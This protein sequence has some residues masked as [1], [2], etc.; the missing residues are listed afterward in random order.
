MNEPTQEQIKRFW[1]HCGFEVIL[2]SY[3]EAP[4]DRWQIPSG[5]MINGRTWCFQNQVSINLN[6]LFRYAVPLLKETCEEWWDV[7]VE[8]AKGITGNYKKDTLALFWAIYKV[9]EG[10][11]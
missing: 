11:S 1:E 2:D 4:T 3:T 10:E 8:W 7:I 6:N 9:I 5:G